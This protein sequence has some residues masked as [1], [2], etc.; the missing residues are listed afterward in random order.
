MRYLLYSIIG[1]VVGGILG[2]LFGIILFGGELNQVKKSQRGAV[3]DIM[4]IPM[5]AIGG[6][7][8]M[9][10]GV[11][12]ASSV[13]DEEM[14]AK[15]KEEIRIQKEKEREEYLNQKRKIY[16]ELGLDLAQHRVFKEGRFWKGESYWINPTIKK[17]YT[18]LTYKSSYG[19]IVST[20]NGEIIK[21]FEETSANKDVIP[22]L[23]YAVRD[24]VFTSLYNKWKEDN[25]NN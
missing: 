24:T 3:S 22:K 25:L 23:H 9:V 2:A 21:E 10:L 7:V 15:I 8:G 18:L 19:K 13:A 11:K 5:L 16:K 20:L 6:V 17:E 4:F 14:E 12:I 1:L